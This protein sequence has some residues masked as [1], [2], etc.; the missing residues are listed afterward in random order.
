MSTLR[1]LLSALLVCSC[2]D[3]AWRVEVRG[4]GGSA[5]TS[6]GGSA[7]ASG[8]PLTCPDRKV[9]T[10]AGSSAGF[11]EG[12]AGPNGIALLDGVHGLAAFSTVSAFVADT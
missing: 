6:G 3:D 4:S 11:K 5:G 12:S 7:G 10:L 1:A 2:A 9:S 8:A